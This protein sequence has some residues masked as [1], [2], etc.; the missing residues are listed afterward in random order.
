R[1]LMN[2]RVVVLPEPEAPT[3]ATKWPSS[4]LSETSSTANVRPP[5]NDLQSFSSSMNAAMCKRLP[6][7]HVIISLSWLDHLFPREA[8][9]PAGGVAP[10]LRRED[11]IRARRRVA[12][13]RAAGD[14]GNLSAP[15]CA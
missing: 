8:R 5:S 2:F 9:P 3:R 7:S 10:E 4:T 13:P 11:F 12:R 1:R 6:G 14:H 15:S